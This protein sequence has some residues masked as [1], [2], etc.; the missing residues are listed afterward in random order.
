MEPTQALLFA[1]SRLHCVF[2]DH[3]AL[4][5]QPDAECLTYFSEY[6]QPQRQVLRHLRPELSAKVTTALAFHNLYSD[7]PVVAL[8]DLFRDRTLSRHRTLTAHWRKEDI[9]TANGVH[10]I[11]SVEGTVSL[12]LAPELFL[13]KVEYPALLEGKTTRWF[14]TASG[15]ITDRPDGASEPQTC[16]QYGRVKHVFSI[17]N[18]PARWAAPLYLLW[19]AVQNST[20]S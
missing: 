4:I 19:Q 16:Y 14:N 1:D 8:T 10:S 12:A 20:P 6:G 13:F 18:Y 7:N 17:G 15:K 3:S 11:T 5:L 9:K 2:A